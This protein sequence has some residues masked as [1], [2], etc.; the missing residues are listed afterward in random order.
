[1]EAVTKAAPERVVF[2]IL[3]GTATRFQ[4]AEPDWKP[5]VDTTSKPATT[6]DAK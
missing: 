3:R 5:M 1:M 4:Y 6:Q 2:E